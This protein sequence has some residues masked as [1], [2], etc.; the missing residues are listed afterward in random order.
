MELYFRLMSVSRKT[1]RVNLTAALNSSSC[2]SSLRSG[3]VDHL[4]FACGLAASAVSKTRLWLSLL[5]PRP[6]VAIHRHR[7]FHDRPIARVRFDLEFA[8]EHFGALAHA[9]QTET[10]VLAGLMRMIRMEGTSVVRDFQ[11]DV[12]VLLEQLELRFRRLRVLLDV[13]QGFLRD[14]EK[15]GVACE[16]RLKNQETLP[17]NRRRRG[18]SIRASRAIAAT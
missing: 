4:Q 18:Q 6:V 11:T 13:V 14:A 2:L 7:R 3:C 5:L 16:R 1:I 9:G 15:A 12:A 10:S 8:A 17:R